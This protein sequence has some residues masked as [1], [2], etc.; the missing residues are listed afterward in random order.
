M[1]KKNDDDPF[2]NSIM[3]NMQGA[4]P[5]AEMNGLGYIAEDLLANPRTRR[6]AVVELIARRTGAD[7]PE[8]GE[9]TYQAVIRLVA[10]EPILVPD[11]VNSVREIRDR[12]RLNRPGQGSFDEAKQ[13]DELSARRAEEGSGR[14]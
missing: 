9:D 8:D 6:F 11:D 13:T 1:A 12:A 10:I 2:K 5:P 3:I 4:M 7:H 14:A